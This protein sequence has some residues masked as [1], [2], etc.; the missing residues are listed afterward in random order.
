MTKPKIALADFSRSTALKAN[1]IKSK[2]VARALDEQ[3]DSLPCSKVF[4]SFEFEDFLTQLTPKRFELLRHCEQRATFR[5]RPRCRLAPQSKR[6][7]PGS[8]QV[9]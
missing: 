8:I 5:C 2:E 1:S 9:V 4:T 7:F 3:S 6:G